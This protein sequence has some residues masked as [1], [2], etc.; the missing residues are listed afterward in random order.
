MSIFSSLRSKQGR[1]AGDERPEATLSED[2][3]ERF[4]SLGEREAIA[5]LQNFNQAELT[6]IHAFERS[7]HERAPVLDKLRYLREREPLPDYDALD[8]QAV[9]ATLASADVDTIKAVREYERKHQNRP[10]VNSA[11]IGALRESRKREPAAAAGSIAP[12]LEGAQAP[13]AGNGLPIKVPPESG[14][15]TP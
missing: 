14:I 9:T 5:E 12:L 1:S 8:S 13:Q 2:L 7:H 15:G 6:E 3:T 4:A 11:I 10:I